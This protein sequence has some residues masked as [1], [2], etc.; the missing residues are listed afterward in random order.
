MS[1]DPECMA[2][3]TRVIIRGVPYEISALGVAHELFDRSVEE[4]VDDYIARRQREEEITKLLRQFRVCQPAAGEPASTTDPVDPQPAAMVP[5]EAQSADV[6]PAI[7]TPA[8]AVPSTSHIPA[9]RV[10]R[11]ALSQGPRAG[12]KKHVQ[13]H[14]D[15]DQQ[16]RSERSDSE[17][18]YQAG[19]RLG[20]Y[21]AKVTA[22]TQA[23]RASASSITFLAALIEAKAMAAA[24]RSDTETMEALAAAQAEFAPLLVQAN[25]M[26]VV[27]ARAQVAVNQVSAL[28][29]RYRTLGLDALSSDVSQQLKAAIGKAMRAYSVAR[30]AHSQI[31]H[32]L[33]QARAIGDSVGVKERNQETRV[34]YF[35]GATAGDSDSDDDLTSL[36]SHF[37]RASLE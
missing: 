34:E 29:G 14:F 4:D 5:A 10:L 20:R 21:C 32:V 23:V 3:A 22:S 33:L 12:A 16:H 30:W 1:S 17:L 18:I 28:A 15:D 35:G 2:G 6:A 24:E 8:E 26:N 25:E 19:R 37:D 27:A 7:M 11:S 9:A 13:F 36:E 31:N